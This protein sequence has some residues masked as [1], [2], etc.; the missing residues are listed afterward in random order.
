MNRF[1]LQ[2][3][4]VMIVLSL[5]LCICSSSW[6]DTGNVG[7]WGDQGDGTYKNP[8]LPGDYPDLDAVR[9]GSDYYAISSTDHFAPGM[10]VLHS[11]DLVNWQIVGHVVDDLTA[12]SPEL[13]WDKMSR[14]GR[15]IWAGSIRYHEGKFWVY[16]FT[17]DDGLFMSTAKD[18]A[19]PWEPLYHMWNV[20]GWDDC[21]PFWDDDGQAYLV[22]TNVA[23]GFEVRLFKMSPDGKY[24][25]LGSDK[26]IHKSLGAANNKLYKFQ[27]NYCHFFSEMHGDNRVL[28]MGRSKNIDGPYETKQLQHV[29]QAVDREPNQGGLVQTEKGDWWLLTHQGTLGW[30][31]RPTSLLPVTW[32]NGWP[33]PG[34]P[35]ADGL[36]TMVWSAKKPVD[37]S[38]VMVPQT[39]DEF[40]GGKLGPQWEWNFQPRKDKW[41]LSERP[42]FLRLHAFKPLA[43]GGVQKAGNTLTQRSMRTAHADATIKMDISNMADGQQAG[44]CHLSETYSALGIFQVGGVRMLIYSDN[45]K[46]T[47][48][49]RITDSNIWLKSNWEEPGQT[50]YQYSLD[51]TTF[52]P[53]GS[54]YTLGWGNYRGDRICIYSYNSVDE[55]G[56]VDVNWFHYSFAGPHSAKTTP[57]MPT[58]P[59]TQP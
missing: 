7:A 15:G 5:S 52:T 17:P 24:L 11:K 25:L 10:V 55:S 1:S 9:V 29:S 44:M 32:I 43:D 4:W 20:T 31:G 3:T 14:Y 13:N 45:G 50:Q 51:G 35:G 6:G 42:G 37:G 38:P 16:F 48:G 53:F 22:A 26:V 19:G 41:S 46:I 33:I 23:A 27:E 36:G 58:V 57:T 12:I 18:P 49:P 54:P 39:D 40:D 34:K 21:C 2:S 8:I 30:D 59:T 28:M 47:A 56:F